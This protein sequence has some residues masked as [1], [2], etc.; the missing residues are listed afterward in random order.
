MTT[1]ITQTKYAHISSKKMKAI[2]KL[3]VGLKVDNA[4]DKLLLFADKGAKLLYQTLKSAQA[5]AKN[6]FKLDPATLK[7]KTVEILKGP[8]MKRWQPVSRGMA[9]SIKKRMA[10]IKVTL[11]N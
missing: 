11:T 5:D 1:V 7:V 10:H 6:N 4:M 9:H 8:F 2:A 3:V